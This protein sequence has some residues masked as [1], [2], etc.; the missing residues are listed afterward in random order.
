[1]L[2]LLLMLFAVIAA[3]YQQDV[4][5]NTTSTILQTFNSLS[6]TNSEVRL[7]KAFSLDAKSHDPKPKPPRTSI[8]VT[9]VC[10]HI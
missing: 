1:V 10:L 4:N 7:T 8:L 3:P 9:V 2:L 6:D 5:R